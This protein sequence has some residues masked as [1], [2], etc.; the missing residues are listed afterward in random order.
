MWILFV[1]FLLAASPAW[2][3][4]SPVKIDDGDTLTDQLDLSVTSGAVV[5]V[6]ASNT[7]RA[8]LN[9]TTTTAVRWG[10]SAVTVSRGQR[11]AAGATVAIRNTAAIYMIA[12]ADTSTVS[13]TEESHSSSSGTIFSP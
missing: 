11:L 8:S 1:V 7:S 6:K 2:A 5:L 13:C 4:G 12:E 3:A 10:T 9:C